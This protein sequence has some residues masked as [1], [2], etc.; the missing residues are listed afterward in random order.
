MCIH[1]PASSSHSPNY[2]YHTRQKALK[3]HT[4]A[5]LSQN[6]PKYHAT[7]LVI[8]WTSDVATLFW[9][10][11]FLFNRNASKIYFIQS[12]VHTLVMCTIYLPVMAGDTA[13]N[14]ASSVPTASIVGNFSDIMSL[15]VGMIIIWTLPESALANWT[16][17]VAYFISEGR[18]WN[19][20][21]THLVTTWLTVIPTF[22]VAYWNLFP[23]ARKAYTICADS[24]SS[25]K[26]HTL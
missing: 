3:A 2:E 11:L 17:V 25:S 23:L 8:A 6:R 24:S 20:S 18:R 22:G 21:L 15:F 7:Y 19:L 13:F 10:D 14:T 26:G 16:S 4:K 5:I 9:K 12:E 1:L